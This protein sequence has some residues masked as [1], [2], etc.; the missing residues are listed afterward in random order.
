M[1][2]PIN[3]IGDEMTKIWEV[4]F[5]SFDKLNVVA[6]DVVEATTKAMKK[7]RRYD[8]DYPVEWIRSVALEAETN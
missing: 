3:I 2:K 4:S 1:E 6:K 5:G 8:K 7:K